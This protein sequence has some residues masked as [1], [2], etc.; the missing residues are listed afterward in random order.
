MSEEPFASLKS[1]IDRL[2]TGWAE[3]TLPVVLE[4]QGEVLL[5]VLGGEI[6]DGYVQL[7]R[8]TTTGPT[9]FRKRGVYGL[10]DRVRRSLRQPRSWF[11]ARAQAAPVGPES[12]PPPDEPDEPPRQG[13]LRADLPGGSVLDL[14][15]DQVLAART[16]EIGF[17]FDDGSSTSELESTVLR[18]TLRRLAADLRDLRKLEK[19]AN[20]HWIEDHPD[21]VANETA[22]RFEQ[23]MIDILNEQVQIASHAPL[24]EDLCQKTDLR[25]NFPSLGRRRGARVQVTSVLNP[26]ELEQKIQKIPNPE[27]MVILSPLHLA[28]AIGRP[29]V[30]E[31]LSTAEM[32]RF[33]ACFPS[34]PVTPGE[35]ARALNGIFF[36]ALSKA[37]AELRDPRGPMALVPEPVRRFVQAYVVAEA[38]RSTRVLRSNQDQGNFLVRRHMG[39]RR[40]ASS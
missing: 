12:G 31:Y 14:R 3:G 25:V 10:V 11:V 2:E 32:T 28:L 22:C 19:G 33:W 26:H 7:A 16:W 8:E 40:R 36:D 21:I 29:D 1:A 18:W 23:L 9:A 37:D 13:R 5:E 15:M 20:P 38:L 17:R 4:E 35:L 6:M 27:E 34:R 30:E 39:L 24:L